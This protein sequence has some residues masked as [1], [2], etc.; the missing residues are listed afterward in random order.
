MSCKNLL[1]LMLLCDVCLPDR[2]SLCSS[3]NISVFAHLWDP[4]SVGEG[5]ET[6][7]IRVWKSLPS[8]CVLE[9]WGWRRYIMGQNGHRAMCQWGRW[10]PKGGRL[11]DSTSVGK[12]N[13][14]FLIRVWKPLPNRR[15]L[16]LWGW[17]WYVTSES[18]QYMLAV[19][20]GC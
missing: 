13:K 14:A 2:T 12:G 18:G 17:R 4:T 9:S 5:N 6:F 20:L 8:R 16:K 15:V 7:L 19:D 10:A 1:V 3:K 11:R